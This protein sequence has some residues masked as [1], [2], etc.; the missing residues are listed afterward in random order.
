MGPQLLPPGGRTGAQVFSQNREDVFSQGKVLGLYQLLE[1]GVLCCPGWEKS[2]FPNLQSPLPCILPLRKGRDSA[3]PG[4][5]MHWEA[6]GD[7][8]LGWDGEQLQAPPLRGSF[9][10]GVAGSKVFQQIENPVFFQQIGDGQSHTA[11]GEGSTVRINHH[12]EPHTAAERSKLCPFVEFLQ[13]IF[14]S[15]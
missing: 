9:L 11:A 12:Q 5:G 7:P 4:A 8:A 15:T 6:V 14:S 3:E 2:G 13:G 10:A 1:T